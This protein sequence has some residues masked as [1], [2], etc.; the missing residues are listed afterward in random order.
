MEDPPH[1]E[2]TSDENQSQA[3]PPTVPTDDLIPYEEEQINSSEEHSPVTS[4]NESTLCD[5]PRLEPNILPSELDRLWERAEQGDVTYQKA[6]EAVRQEKR[7]F[8]PELKLKV[9]IAEC[10]LSSQGKLMFRGRR[11]VP[12]LEELRTKLSQEVHDSRA[13]GHPGRDNHFAILARRFFWPRMSQDIRRFVRNCDSCGRNKAWRDRRQGFL[14]PLPIPERIWQEISIDFVVDLPPSEGRT[15]MIVITDRLGKGVICDGLENIQAETVAKWFVRNYY[16][17]HHL[18]RAIVSDR[19]TQFVGSLWSRICSL[20]G[21]VRRLSTAYHPETDGATER[22]NQELEVYLRTFTNHAQN[23]WHELLP[24]AEIAINGKNAASTGVSPFFLEHGYHV[25][26]LDITED[27]LESVRDSPVAKAD[28]IVRKLQA[29][30]DWA[31]IAMTHA[32]QVQENATNRFRQQAPSFKVGD[33]V[34][35]NLTNIRTTRTSKK[36]DAKHAKFTVIE[37]VGSHSYRL[38]TPPGIHNVFHSKL[39]RPASSDPLPSQIQDD[40]QPPPQII[41]DDE[42]YEVEEIRDEKIVRRRGQEKRQF[43]VKWTG[44]AR[45][46]WEPYEALQDTAALDRWEERR[47]VM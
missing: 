31:Q 9:S 38:D 42:E 18:P 35:L 41:G 25:D 47:G 30:R 3:P 12:E 11:W 36:L 20:L 39:L 17:R 28:R 7:L 44:Y 33:K 1:G 26:P 15:N 43:L 45:P 4:D 46:T 10:S 24:S 19:G 29:A 16:R 14:K 8:P 34:W 37:V 40:T 32:Q 27:L 13:C 5:E 21:I 2:Q 23:N 22:K 6:T